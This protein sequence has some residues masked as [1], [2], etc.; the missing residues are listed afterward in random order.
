MESRI[1]VR[2]SAVII[3]RI[4]AARFTRRAAAR[5][6]DVHPEFPDL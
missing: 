4:P 5:S 2:V 3:C 1:E 6:L